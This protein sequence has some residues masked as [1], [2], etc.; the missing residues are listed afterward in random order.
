MIGRTARQVVS[1]KT[2][3]PTTG[4]AVETRDVRFS[5]GT[6]LSE[7]SSVTT[8]I[9]VNEK[10][11]VHFQGAGNIMNALLTCMHECFV[12]TYA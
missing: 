9:G 5:G 8:G 4:V 7:H 11:P 12:E 3:Q 6:R 2:R 1:K 10:W